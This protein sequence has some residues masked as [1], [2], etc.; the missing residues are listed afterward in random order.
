MR[1]AG[2]RGLRPPRIW[3]RTN[4]TNNERAELMARG[5]GRGSRPWP[6]R[7]GLVWPPMHTVRS[8]NHTGPAYAPESGAETGYDSPKCRWPSQAWMKPYSILR[9]WACGWTKADLEPRPQGRTSD[10]GDSR[11]VVASW[12]RADVMTRRTWHH[13]LASV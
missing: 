1:L 13:T 12:I 3:P 5:N 8:P 4:P 6:R 10:S 9:V 2:P 11:S 7:D